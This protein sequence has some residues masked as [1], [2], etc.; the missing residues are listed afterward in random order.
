M[1]TILCMYRRLDW[2]QPLAVLDGHLVL[3]RLLVEDRICYSK[4]ICVFVCGGNK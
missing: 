1:L 2:L 3:L 4:E